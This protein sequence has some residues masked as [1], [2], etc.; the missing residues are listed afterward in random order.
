VS[1]TASETWT[2]YS[3][4][5]CFKGRF[6]GAE[7]VLCGSDVS[8]ACMC[9]FCVF[10]DILITEYFLITDSARYGG[11]SPRIHFALRAFA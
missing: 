5:V 11:P 1:V 2:S 3:K 6:S 10:A 7:A 4:I 9:M 8:G